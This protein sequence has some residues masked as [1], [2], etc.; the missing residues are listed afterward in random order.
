M[1]APRLILDLKKYRA[2]KNI[3]FLDQSG[4]KYL[5]KKMNSFSVFNFHGALNIYS[6]Q[7]RIIFLTYEFAQ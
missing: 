7:H 6:R 4:D 1:F 5:Q 2:T 3:A